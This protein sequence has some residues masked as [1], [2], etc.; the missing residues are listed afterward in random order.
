MPDPSNVCVAGVM[1]GLLEKIELGRPPDGLTTH[2]IQSDRFSA[3]DHDPCT[4]QLA[5]SPRSRSKRVNTSFISISERKVPYLMY[6]PPPP[7]STGGDPVGVPCTSGTR[8]PAASKVWLFHAQLAP[9][10]TLPASGPLL[11]TRELGVFVNGLA[12]EPLP[13]RSQACPSSP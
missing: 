2:W 12:G 4:Y 7:D 8:L 10:T 11:N 5:L 13:V 6:A 9:H 3:C 1:K